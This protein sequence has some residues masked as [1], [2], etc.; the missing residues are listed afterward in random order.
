VE[1]GLGGGAK[2]SDISCVWWDFRLEKNDVHAVL[3]RLSLIC[4]LVRQGHKIYSR[5]RE[6]I[7]VQ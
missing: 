5:E 6:K 2:T 3:V 4:I 1:L 7:P